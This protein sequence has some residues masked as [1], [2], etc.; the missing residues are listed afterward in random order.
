MV[1]SEVIMANG[2]KIFWRDYFYGIS[3]SL[4]FALIFISK[5]ES[6]KLNNQALSL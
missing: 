3:I 2:Y 6:T 5:N 4:D 1:L